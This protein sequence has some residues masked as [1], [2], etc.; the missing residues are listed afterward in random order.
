MGTD[1]GVDW[2]TREYSDRDKREIEIIK[3]KS[4]CF[5]KKCYVPSFC[6]LMELLVFLST[7]PIQF[8]PDRFLSSPW[9]LSQ[10]QT[11]FL[12]V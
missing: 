4:F 8:T 10:L 3:T 7:Y 5:V 6:S 12:E 11:N 1:A 9:Q 2:D